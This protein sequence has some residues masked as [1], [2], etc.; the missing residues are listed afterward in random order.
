MALSQLIP[1]V[2][3]ELKALAHGQLRKVAS[4][5]TLNTTA[6]VHEAYAKLAGQDHPDWENRCHF[7][8]VAATAMRHVAVD[9]A[10]SKRTA[11][12]GGGRS[13]VTLDPSRVAGDE[14]PEAVLA[15]DE[16]LQRGRPRHEG[17]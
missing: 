17:C 6:L 1:L 8:G 13:D 12:R 3:D 7:L 14:G 16:A 11:K 9:Y 5:E 4:S 2:Y 15:I 10:R